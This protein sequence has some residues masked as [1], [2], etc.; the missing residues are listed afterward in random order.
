M[1]TITGKLAYDLLLEAEAYILEDGNGALMYGSPE[2]ENEG[3]YSLLLEYWD[4]GLGY[5]YTFYWTAADEI[6]IDK[7]QIFL[8]EGENEEAIGIKLLQVQQL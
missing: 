2:E 1:K 7:N 6:T 8:K 4:E 3:E 5:E